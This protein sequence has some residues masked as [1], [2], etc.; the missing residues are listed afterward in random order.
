RRRGDTRARGAKQT[1]AAWRFDVISDILL[2]LALNRMS[3]LRPYEKQSIEEI[4][5]S[6]AFFRALTPALLTSILGRT[7]RAM[8]TSADEL[9]RLAARDAEFL[10]SREC[11]V[12]SIRDHRYPAA[13]REIFDPPYLL[14]VRGELP[15]GDLPMVAVVGTRQPSASAMLA[16]HDLGKGLASSG[17]AVVSGLARGIDAA[18]HQGAIEGGVT[19]AVLASGV[20]LI[21]PSSNKPLAAAILSHGGFLLSEYAPGVPPLKYHFP[22]RN[23]IISGLARGV[24]VIQAPAKSGALITADYALDQGR[25]LFV[26]RD[27]LDTPAGAGTAD[28]AADGALIVSCASDVLGEWGLVAATATDRSGTPDR[29]S[30]T[31]RSNGDAAR[32]RADAVRRSLYG[33]V[34]T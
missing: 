21:T 31:V 27:G 26:H 16:A 20:D 33:E 30:V 6:E 11:H 9:L 18:A 2:R 7:I 19:G 15:A 22:A 4:I 1:P 25:D 5:D 24:V 8:D 17:V 3:V 29:S 10:R 32:A 13:L 34:A 12:L 23:R 28:L 14:Y